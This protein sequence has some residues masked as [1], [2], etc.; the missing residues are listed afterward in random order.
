VDKV[1]IGKLGFVASETEEGRKLPNVSMGDNSHGW[2]CHS[3]A[4]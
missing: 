2:L 1:L 4:A 3:D